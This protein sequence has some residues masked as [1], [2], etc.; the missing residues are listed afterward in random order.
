MKTVWRRYLF[1]GLL[2]VGVDLLLPVGL[3]RDLVCSLIAA[4]GAAA[5]YESVRRNRPD[6]PSAWHVLAGGM[7]FWAVGMALYSWHKHANPIATFP[8]LADVAYLAAYPLIAGALLMFARGRGCERTSGAHRQ[9]A[10]TR[11]GRPRRRARGTSR[12][13]WRACARSRAPSPRPRTPCRRPGRAMRSGGRAG[14]GG[15]SRRSP[16]RRRRRSGCRPGPGR[17]RPAARGQPPL[18]EDRQRDSAATPSS[19]HH[20]SWLATSATFSC[21][22]CTTFV[23]H[24][25]RDCCLLY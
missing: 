23:R 5:I 12:S 1:V 19:S 7:A 13:D 11:R 8:S 4:S 10:D 20:L 18:R 9:S 24:V 6:H 2:A 15:R 21:S 17:A 16:Q 3:G 14:S 25:R 22:S